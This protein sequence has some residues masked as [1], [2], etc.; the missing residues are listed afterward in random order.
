MKDKVV[1]SNEMSPSLLF[2]SEYFIFYFYGKDKSGGKYEE[3][4]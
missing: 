1:T 2:M 4:S 3:V